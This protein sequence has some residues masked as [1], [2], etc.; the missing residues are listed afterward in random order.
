H[1]RLTLALLTTSGFAALCAPA[2]AQFFDDIAFF[3]DSLSDPGNIP[4]TTGADFPPAPYVGN[5]FS[6]GPVY[7]ELVPGQLGVDAANVANSAHGGAFTAQIQVPGA[8]PGFTTGN[9]NDVNFGGPVPGLQNTDI[10]TQLLTEIG[11]AGGAA[12]FNENSLVTIYGGPNDYFA[13]LGTSFDPA[14][15]VTGQVNAQ[16]GQTVGNLATAGGIAAASGATQIVLPNVPSLATTPN[17]NTDPTAAGLAGLITDT[18]NTAL[19]GAAVSLAEST[20]ATVYV[21]DFATL[22]ADAVANPE[23]F[24]FTNVTDQC[25]T[26]PTCVAGGQAAQDEFLFWDAVHPTAA[27]QA[28]Q[29]AFFTDTIL[30]PRTLAAQAET[31]HIAGEGFA[32]RLSSVAMLGGLGGD[33][34]IAPFAEATYISADRD[35]EPFAVGYDTTGGRFTVGFV[36]SVSDGL[37]AGMAAAFDLGETDLE[38]GLGGFDYWAARF[39]AF[40]GLRQ[41]PLTIGASLSV[42]LDRYRDIARNTNVA[43]QVA[44]GETDGRTFAV[45]LEGS[46][47]IGSETASIAPI[48]RLSYLNSS[49]DGYRETGAVGLD[50]IVNRRGLETASGAFGARL[51]GAF[52]VGEAVLKPRVTG[53]YEIDFDDSAQTISTALVTIADLERRFR[54]QGLDDQF[55]R[56]EAGATLEFA[57]RYALDVY[58]DVITSADDGEGFMAGLRLISTF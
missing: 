30:A 17:F 54:T 38:G 29:A 26:T 6:N 13:F 44:E 9:L 35:S 16:V 19:T 22:G 48:A 21:V 58:G 28:L 31:A 25:I 47:D 5:R 18:H 24:G 7:A 50:Q 36:K 42:G 56:I 33:G 11:T 51:Q 27:A 53:L 2:Q 14:G 8:P 34:A 41:G 23:K 40:G 52:D 32:R 57:E 55:V 12:R 20:G 3:G 37:S 46:Y 1:R 4:V 45:T 43:G 10:T 49:V 15:S 39:G